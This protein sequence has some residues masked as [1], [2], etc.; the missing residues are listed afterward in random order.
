VFR[1]GRV[2]VAVLFTWTDACSPKHATVQ[3]APSGSASHETVAPSA[4][5]Q[6]PRA[7]VPAFELRPVIE[8]QGPAQ[9]FRMRRGGSIN[10]GSEVIVAACDVSEATVLNDNGEARVAVALFPAA[11]E[12]FE[13]F[14]ERN[15][16]RQ[17]AIVV[18]GIVTSAP[19]LR[20]RI[21]GGHI[22]VS[23]IP[24]EEAT[25]LAERLKSREGCAG[26]IGGA[27]NGAGCAPGTDRNARVTAG[28]GGA[29]N[30]TTAL[31]L[32]EG[33]KRARAC[34]GFNSGRR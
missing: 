1:F 31:V 14:T 24:L 10:L 27:A 30:D 3:Q 9:T 21:G 17:L 13:D 18:D 23:D 6:L 22:T 8:G 4:S 25:R 16:G 33:T 11:V 7:N 34:R 26:T 19:V 29:A 32:P 20:T 2:A 12:A 28:G 5:A 15:V